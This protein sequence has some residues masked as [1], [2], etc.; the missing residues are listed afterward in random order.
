MR[1]LRSVALARLSTLVHLNVC[2]GLQ[3]SNDWDEFAPVLHVCAYNL[4]KGVHQIRRKFPSG[5]F[6]PRLPRIRFPFDPKCPEAQVVLSSD[7]SR[8]SVLHTIYLNVMFRIY[9]NS[10]PLIQ[11]FRQ[12]FRCWVSPGTYCSRVHL[13][14]GSLLHLDDASAAARVELTVAEQ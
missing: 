2:D 7:L 1:L 3:Q 11:V 6:G 10:H 13:V 14:W 4:L 9:P 12:L 8:W 5:K